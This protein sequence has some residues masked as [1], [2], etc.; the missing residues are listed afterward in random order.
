MKVPVYPKNPKGKT[1]YKLFYDL[2]M[3]PPFNNNPTL[4]SINRVTGIHIFIMFMFY[5]IV[6]VI[7]P[8]IS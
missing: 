1:V 4:T 8:H 7:K 5:G 6:F 3:Q 2:S